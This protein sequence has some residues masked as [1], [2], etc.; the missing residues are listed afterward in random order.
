VHGCGGD[1]QA[2]PLS[3]QAFKTLNLTLADLDS[4]LDDFAENLSEVSGV[5]FAPEGVDAPADS[6]N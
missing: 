4:G 2:V 1:D 5:N 6:A 3:P